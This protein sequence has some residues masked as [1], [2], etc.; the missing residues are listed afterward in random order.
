MLDGQSKI[1]FSNGKNDAEC[2][3]DFASIYYCDYCEYCGDKSGKNNVVAMLL[4]N[5]GEVIYC[6]KFQGGQYF[7]SE[8]QTTAKIVDLLKN[9]GE[10][11]FNS[12][13]E[14]KVFYHPHPFQYKDYFN[15]LDKL[16][17]DLPKISKEDVVVPAIIEPT[18][19]PFHMIRYLA[20]N[21]YRLSKYIHEI[22]GLMSHI[23][24]RNSDGHSYARNSDDFISIK[25]CKH[26]ENECGVDLVMTFND[27]CFIRDCEFCV[28]WFA[29]SAYAGI[30]EQMKKEIISNLHDISVLSGYPKIK[31]KNILA[32]A[33]SARFTM[34]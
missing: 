4:M 3:D 8:W 7:K 32:S 33:K 1:I 31:K 16:L 9:N 27:I 11:T 15:E 28:G 14:H 6:N 24:A 30:D 19:N 21:R 17:S 18:G 12:L 10:I 26:E 20:L 25:E 5:I 13:V 2:N 34:V 22:Y 29:Y 23:S